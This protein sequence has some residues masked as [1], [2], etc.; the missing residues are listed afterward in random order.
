MNTF[1]LQGREGGKEVAQGGDGSS[2][3]SVSKCKGTK[4][5]Q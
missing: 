4:S 5:S 1:D 3:Y 2:N